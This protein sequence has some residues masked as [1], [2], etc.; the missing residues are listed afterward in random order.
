MGIVTTR[1]YYLDRTWLGRPSGY[2]DAF[3]VGTAQGIAALINGPGAVLIMNLTGQLLGVAIF[4]TWTGFLL[5]RR[6]RGKKT[7]T[8]RQ[9]WTPDGLVSVWLD[10]RVLVLLERG[11]VL[12]F[13]VPRI[14]GKN[15]G[16]TLA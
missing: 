8:I 12:E 2:L 6:L 7:S 11:K 14:R 3:T 5:D 16:A 10:P 4:W 9:F 1:L 13:C 15:A